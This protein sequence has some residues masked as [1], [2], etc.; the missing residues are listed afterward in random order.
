MSVHPDCRGRKVSWKLR[1]PQRCCFYDLSNS[2]V[3]HDI[4]SVEDLVV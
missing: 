3:C 2:F 1:F 4:D